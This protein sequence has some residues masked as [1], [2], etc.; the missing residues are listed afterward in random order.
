[1][2]LATYADDIILGA[3]KKDSLR[4]ATE[5]LVETEKKIGFIINTNKTKCI[6]M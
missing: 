4:K 6:Y 5:S 3:R 1:M 2:V